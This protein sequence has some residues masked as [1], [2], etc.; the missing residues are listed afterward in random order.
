MI[1]KF[2][3]YQNLILAKPFTFRSDTLLPTAVVASNFVLTRFDSVVIIA[4]GKLD[5]IEVL[6]LF[7]ATGMSFFTIAF[8]LILGVII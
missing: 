6:G 7:P 2:I 5:D 3:S 4:A 8:V 1:A